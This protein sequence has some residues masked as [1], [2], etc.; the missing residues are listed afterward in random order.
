MNIKF[1][2]GFKFKMTLVF[3]VTFIL[4]NVLFSRYTYLYFKKSFI[5]NYNKYLFSRAT[6]L[7]NKTEI[8]PDLIALPDTGESIRVFYHNYNHQPII[9]F[10]SPGNIK[11]VNPPFQSGVVDTLDVHGVYLKKENYDGRPVELLLTVSNFNLT[12]RLKKLSYLMITATLLSV[13]IS[14]IA[15]Y[16]AAGWLLKPIRFIIGQATAINS[17]RL[18]ERLQVTET[19]DELQQLTETI[20]NMF[21]RIEQEQQLQNNFFAAA[22]HELRTPLAILQAETELNL[23]NHFSADITTFLKS[24]LQEIVRLQ[25]I[26]QQFLLVSQLKHNGLKLFITEVDIAGQL[27]KVFE[28]NSLLLKQSGLKTSL[29]FDEEMQSFIIKGDK[30]KLETVWQNFVQNVI[31]Y[32][33]KNSMVICNVSQ[34]GNDVIVSFENKI[35]VKQIPINTLGKAFQSSSSIGTSTGLGLWLCKQIVQLHHGKIDF[36]SSNYS[37]TVRVTLSNC[38]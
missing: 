1:Y 3:S 26:V 31:K 22:S 24:Q 32:A 12:N 14:A 19:H 37:F 28:R 16:I 20:N 27:L 21:G 38:I 34:I 11:F 35:T 10:Q 17:G 15:V 4:I 33:D 30:D 9:V 8:N 6:A 29:V 23:G 13:L 2:K 25:H 7:I 36:Y 5:E 18:N